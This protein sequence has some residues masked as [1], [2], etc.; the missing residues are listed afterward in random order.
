MEKKSNFS[1]IPNWLVGKFTGAEYTLY[2][3]MYN[4]WCLMQ[5]ADGWYYR[6]LSKLKEDLNITCKNNNKLLERIKKFE[7]LGILTVK[8]GKQETN[9]YKFNEHFMFN[10]DED[11][12]NIGSTPKGY[13]GSTPKGYKENEGV[14]PQ[15]G[16][17]YNTKE[18][19]NDNISRDN[20]TCTS[21]KDIHETIT[22][23]PE[24]DI[25]HETK[26]ET[27]VHELESVEELTNENKNK[28]IPADINGYQ[29]WEN[30][31]WYVIELTSRP[32]DDT[33]RY[34]I[35]F[36]HYG[37]LS[38]VREALSQLDNQELAE[39]LNNE[40]DNCIQMLKS[41]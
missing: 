31:T 20:S 41:A 27:I 10:N 1:T 40:I 8:R 7:E 2:F 17:I 15:K 37:E 25:L 9:W 22:N 35:E 33:Y 26:P 14:V 29:F 4:G 30:P 36:I 38:K 28:T 16:T 5:D 32:Y 34:L 6:S 11:A 39:Q 24:T 3:K 19:K 18:N 21:N 23:I 13:K 12:T